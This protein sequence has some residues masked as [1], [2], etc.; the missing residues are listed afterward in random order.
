ML[1]VPLMNRKGIKEPDD[2]GYFLQVIDL[3]KARAAVLDELVDR[4]GYCFSDEFGYD[5]EVEPVLKD[6]RPREL[7]GTGVAHGRRRVEHQARNTH[8]PGAHGGVGKKSRTRVVRTSGSTGKDTRVEPD[9]AVD[10]LLEDING[11]VY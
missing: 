11:A 7:T 8:S 10:G 9:A 5:E 6:P 3:F 1:I 2:T 4:T